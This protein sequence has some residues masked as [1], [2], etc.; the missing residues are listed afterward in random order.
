MVVVDTS[1]HFKHFWRNFFF[2]LVDEGKVLVGLSV[3]IMG[4]LRDNYE[5]KGRKKK[6]KVRLT[7]KRID[8]IMATMHEVHSHGEELWRF[9][10]EKDDVPEGVAEAISD[11][12]DYHV[13]LKAIDCGAEYIIT[14]DKGD[15]PEKYTVEETGKTI[16]I[17]AP[18]P[19]LMEMLTVYRSE[20]DNMNVF[21]EAFAFAAAIVGIEDMDDFLDEIYDDHELPELDRMLRSELD[22]LEAMLARSRS[23][24]GLA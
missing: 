14:A 23:Q 3:N 13:V 18:Y 1:V 21:L 4:E 6:I 9:D 11:K 15:F 2:Q 17:F 16:G 8:Q 24:L 10:P 19:W 5:G 7:Q 20:P 12:D 22:E